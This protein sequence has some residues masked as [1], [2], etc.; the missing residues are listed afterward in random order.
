M[1][2]KWLIW[3]DNFYFNNIVMIKGSLD[4]VS[5]S[6]RNR[7][8]SYDRSKKKTRNTLVV[9]SDSLK[10]QNHKCLT[11]TIDYSQLTL[12]K[13]SPPYVQTTIPNSTIN[14]WF[15]TQ[16]QKSSPN[17]MSSSPAKSCDKG[18]K[19]TSITQAL[20]PQ[21]KRIKSSCR[22]K[23]SSFETIAELEIG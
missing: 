12:D 21:S 2:R 15:H 19:K 20:Y 8:L 11:K 6:K 14:N 3:V 10:L 17:K 9:L 7:T 16:S 22:R 5:P 4:E 23:K 13:F 1:K 18:A